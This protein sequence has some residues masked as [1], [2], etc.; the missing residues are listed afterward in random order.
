MQQ[1]PN[2]SPL[3]G[4]YPA[5]LVDGIVLRLHDTVASAGDEWRALESNGFSTVYQSFAWSLT[6]EQSGSVRHN[7]Q[8]LIISGQ[9]VSGEA[10]FIFPLQLHVS[11]RLK[12]VEF[13]SAPL[14]SYGHLA[15]SQWC[16]SEAGKGWFNSHF[17]DLLALCEPYDLLLLRDMPS[18]IG[19]VSHPLAAH[20][21]LRAPNAAFTGLL[22]GT[23]EE[24]INSRR[25][26]NSRKN[27]RWKNS[28][29]DQAGKLSFDAGLR[30]SELREAADELFSDQ[31]RRLEEAG[32][33][34]PFGEAEREFYHRLL[35][36]RISDTRFNVMRL[37]V[38]GQG[39]SSIFAAFHR[40]TCS[41][42]MTSLAASPLRK[43]SPGDLVLRKVIAHC[44]ENG[45]TQL[46]LGI[47]DHDYKRLW[48][49]DEL[50][51]HHIVK[52]RTLKGVVAA[53]AVYA[54]QLITRAIKSNRLLRGWFNAMRRFLRG[55]TTV[56]G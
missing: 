3:V 36:S 8:P 55:N 22:A 20:F 40:G 29:L 4:P 18:A 10:M 14:A 44:Y 27:L 15:C 48:A 32:I 34:D 47:G 39:L 42:F 25:S 6:W 46:D 17:E 50:V 45:I 5:A 16:F 49:S 33:R 11:K 54:K 2:P 19:G 24:F 30:G 23:F 41:D 51:L 43:Y 21:N 28:K 26:A 37:S 12:T 53:C 13:L 9:S 31:G 52:G 56:A 1:R 7:K 35:E 38:D